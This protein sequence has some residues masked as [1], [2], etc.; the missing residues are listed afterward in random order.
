MERRNQKLIDF[1]ISSSA[2]GATRCTCAQIGQR[3]YQVIAAADDAR[4]VRLWRINKKDSL[5]NFQGHSS[6]ITTVFF[7]SHEEEVYSGSFGGTVIVWDINSKKALHS[8]KGHMASCTTIAPYP[9]GQ[10]YLL[11]T[12]SADCNIK[13]WDLRRKQCIQTFKGHKGQVNVVLFRPDSRWVASGGVDG[14]IKLWDLNTSKKLFDFSASESPVSDMKFNPQNL[15]LASSHADR[16]IQ[17]WDLENMGHVSNTQPEANV[18]QKICFDP[19][20]SRF[21]FSAGNDSLKLW[22]IE[23]SRL[24]DNIESNWKGVEDLCVYTRESMIF[25]LTLNSGSMSLWSTDLKSVCYSGRVM[26]DFRPAP[27][28]IVAKRP[29]DKPPKKSEPERK[30]ADFSTTFVPVGD[31]PI[32]LEFNEFLPKVQPEVENLKLLQELSENHANMLAVLNRRSENIC[33]ILKWWDSGNMPAALNALNMMNDLS[34]TADVLKHGLTD[35]KNEW[36]TLELCGQVIPLAGTLVESKYE[37]YIKTGIS[38]ALTLTKQFRSVI[39]STL[40][41]PSSMGVDLSRED[42]IKR[43]EVC[44]NAFRNVCDSSALAK[45]ARRENQTGE[46]ARELKRTLEGFI[47]ECMRR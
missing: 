4:N 2:P 29:E 30:N 35:T 14:T 39:S 5:I 16:T 27:V 8:L 20:D 10:Q 43:C 40:S 38:V 37:S 33:L 15:T 32:G 36:I 26:E 18:I 31:K 34:V 23:E 1:D 46:L 11:A 21:L 45:N 9:T 25:G 13:I 44:F 42:R 41:A 28:N 24:L 19:E 3:S 6:D 17:Y 22:D 12:G 47:A 7:S